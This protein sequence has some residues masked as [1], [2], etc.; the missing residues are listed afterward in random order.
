[1][2]S[3]HFHV[4]PIFVRKPRSSPSRARATSPQKHVCPG[5]IPEFAASVELREKLSKD[6]DTFGEDVDSVIQVCTQ[7]F[8]EFL[9]EDYGGPGTLRAD[10]FTD[11]LVALKA[12]DLPGAALAA[13]ASL[14]WSGL[15]NLE[16]ETIE[17]NCLILCCLKCCKCTMNVNND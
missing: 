16:R 11:M 17:L 5:P 2:A 6:I 3:S 12:N 8:S 1:M 9:H 4:K 10:A 14:L 15:G 7:I 13:R